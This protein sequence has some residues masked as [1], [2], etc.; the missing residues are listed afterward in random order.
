MAMSKIIL[1]FVETYSEWKT[2]FAKVTI[3]ANDLQYGDVIGEGGYNTLDHINDN[4]LYFL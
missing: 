4:T 1:N 3:D 2:K